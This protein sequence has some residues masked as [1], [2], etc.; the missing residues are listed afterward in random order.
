MAMTDLSFSSNGADSAERTSSCEQ[1]VAVAL[2]ATDWQV[3]DCHL[4]S[5]C[6]M[7]LVLCMTMPL[8]ISLLYKAIGN[9]RGAGR[10]S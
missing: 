2:F 7:Q 6:F 10:N 9:A 3:C 4:I 8:R 1:A 5:V